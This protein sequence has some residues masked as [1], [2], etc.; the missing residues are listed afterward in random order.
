MTASFPPLNMS[1]AAY[2]C[3]I[4]YFFAVRQCSFFLTIGLSV[5]TCLVHES[6]LISWIIPT[7]T[8][9]A[10][11]S[12]QYSSFIL[13]VISLIMSIWFILFGCVIHLVVKKP[14]HLFILP[15][16]W[17]GIEWLKQLG[18]LA[19][20][21]ELLGYSQYQWIHLIQIAD[22]LGVYGISGF[23]MLINV[24]GFIVFLFIVHRPWKKKYI[25]KHLMACSLMISIGVVVFLNIYGVIRISE[26][27][28]LIARSPHK[29]IMIVQPSVPQSEKWKGE[30]RLPIT[31][32][33]VHLT[34]KAKTGDVDLVVW[35]ETALPY[36]LHSKHKL[37]Q[38]ILNAQ[39]HMNTGLVT[40]SPAFVYKNGQMHHYNS[41]YV[42]NEK[43]IIHSRYDKFRRVPFSEYMP[44]Y[45][46]RNLWLSLGAPEEKFSP[47]RTGEIHQLNDLKM[48]IQICFEI[49]FPQY[50]RQMANNGANVL[51]NI[52]NDAWFG[53]S[54]CPY[55][56]FSMAVF[57]AVE[58][59]RALIRCANTGISGFIDPWGRILL[60]T[61]LFEKIAITQQVPL[62]SHK[63]VY[64]RIGDCFAVGAVLFVL[65]W[66]ICGL[67]LYAIRKK[68]PAWKPRQ[69]FLG[70]NNYEE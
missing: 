36:A 22:C 55:Q 16:A 1:L 66:I 69:A 47:G 35:P 61:G 57:R 45:S 49:V 19:F 28:D 53:R 40:G 39:K 63:T 10:K 68:R 38:Y 9:Q 46:L 70:K 13:F 58:N 27:N 25:S 8:T 24:T 29:S 64:S 7:L 20:P 3:W 17:V 5:L 48:G 21:W 41:A 23:V 52:S 43:G 44:F 12:V 50:A 31:Q 65:G 15:F 34:Y 37:R 14:G 67:L 59:K 26:T 32:T 33:M 4:P 11:F 56:H 2:I 42:I 30:N 54:A 62:I 6:I 60:Q 18:P 51:I